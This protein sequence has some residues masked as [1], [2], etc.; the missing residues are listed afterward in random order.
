MIIFKQRK[1]VRDSAAIAVKP[2][3]TE[4]ESLTIS[5]LK[6][7]IRRPSITPFDGGCQELIAEFLKP[8]GFQIEHLRFGEVDNLWARRGSA[9]P[10]LVFAGHTDVVP[11]GAEQ[12]WRFPPFHPSEHQ[13]YLYGRGAADMKGSIAAMLSAC[14]QFIRD[15]P[16]HFASI[17][18]LITSDEEGPSIDGTRKVVE[19]LKSRGEKIRWCIVG[20]PSSESQLGDTLKIG[21]R[22]SLSA[23]LEI[24]GKQGHIAYP[25]LAENPI[26]RC[27]QAL[28]QLCEKTWDRGN[29]RFP[30][31]SFQISNIHAGQGTGNVIPGKVEILFN[32]RYSPEQTPEKLQ[33][34]VSDILNARG[35]KYKLDW[36][37]SGAPFMG[38]E[39]KLLAAAEYAIKNVMGITPVL[40]TGG[41]T[42]DGRFII[43][44]CDEL[45]ELGPCNQSIHHIDE[46]VKIGDLKSLAHIYYTI[47]V[48]L[49]TEREENAGTN[50]TP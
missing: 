30:P 42:S 13:G 10:L 21:R 11:P 26:H 17:A 9:G 2:W 43:E 29:E 19:L 25:Q 33:G 4:M 6:N 47:L 45:L 41:G 36:Q 5:L 1:Q 23:K 31:T 27:L 18:F 48:Q 8:L 3:V 35:L 22:G 50:P 15:Y 38:K 12:E 32:F 14:Q 39:D 20:E 16:H 37:H 46:C 44:I 34:E 24:F 7:L 49:L 28:L 40:S